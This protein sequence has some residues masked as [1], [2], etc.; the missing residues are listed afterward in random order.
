MRGWVL[1]AS[2]FLATPGAA[3]TVTYT[4]HGNDIRCLWQEVCDDYE[5]PLDAVVD[6]FSGA[7]TI[8]EGRYP[9][10][11][12]AGT[13][14]YLWNEGEP[15][16]FFAITTDFSQGNP[17]PLALYD[18][19]FILDD[20]FIG[21]FVWGVGWYSDLWITFD[22]GGRIVDWYGQCLCGGGLSDGFTGPWGDSL[23]N[24][25]PSAPGTWSMRRDQPVEIIPLPAAGWMLLGG[26]AV[27]VAA[28]GRWRAGHRRAASRR[29]PG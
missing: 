20:S 29:A 11:A 9:G 3:A 6:N 23:G 26:L 18:R 2:L 14:L 5:Y 1:A 19:G 12:V 7:F 15:E 13:T 10:G 24:I 16:L 8:D 4:Y 22:A 25:G 17:P 27:L 21:R 28:R